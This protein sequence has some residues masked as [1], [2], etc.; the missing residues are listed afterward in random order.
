MSLIRIVLD[1]FLPKG[2]WHAGAVA[3]DYYREDFSKIYH[4]GKKSWYLWISLLIKM[5]VAMCTIWSKYLQYVPACI[6][7]KMWWGIKKG[8][9]GEK[10]S[11]LPEKFLESFHADTQNLSNLRTF[12]LS[13]DW[14]SWAVRFFSGLFYVKSISR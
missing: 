3:L 13:I 2:S 12:F 11:K 14:A 7:K 6:C 4:E 1:A 8:G 5:V 10:Q 9:N